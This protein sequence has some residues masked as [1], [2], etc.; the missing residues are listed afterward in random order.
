[1][2]QSHL[3]TGFGAIGQSSARELPAVVPPRAR[4]TEQPLLPPA[5]P[6]RRSRRGA[7]YKLVEFRRRTLERMT[8][9][10]W[11]PEGTRGVPIFGRVLRRGTALCLVCVLA[12][13]S[14]GALAG[15]SISAWVVDEGQAAGLIGGV[16]APTMRGI[17]AYQKGDVQRAERE[18]TRAAH[19]YPRSA[20]ALL[21]LARIRSDAG[22]ADRAAAYLG[23]AVA[24]DPESAVAHRM[25]GEYRLTRARRMISSGAS[26]TQALSELAAAESE[27]AGSVSLDPLDQRARGYHACVL[28]MLGRVDQARDAFAAAGSGPWEDC[29][30]LPMR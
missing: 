5:H 2:R 24:R 28:S 20:L 4:T 27:L 21:Y 8:A 12:L 26:Q 10:L 22:D 19:S 11:A 17:T 14:I 6:S 1:M 30:R 18:L 13:A 3:S 15:D 9:A 23:E 16:P 25:L 29:V 7:R